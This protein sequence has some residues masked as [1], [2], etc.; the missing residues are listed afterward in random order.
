[1]FITEETQTI[2]YT[3]KEIED[4]VMD[5]NEKMLF[6]KNWKT[7]EASNTQN[8]VIVKYRK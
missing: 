4:K 2:F 5:K 7:V 1:M 3:W 8:G 6:S